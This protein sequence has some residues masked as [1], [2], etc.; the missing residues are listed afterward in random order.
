MKTVIPIDIFSVPKKT[1]AEFVKS[2]HKIAE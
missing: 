1:E 2:R